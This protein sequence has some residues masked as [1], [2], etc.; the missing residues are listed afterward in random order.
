MGIRRVLILGDSGFMGS[1]L[2][3]FFN[4]KSPDVEV[5]GRSKDSIDLTKED[6]AN[7]LAGLLDTDTAIVMCAA[8]KK[9]LGDSLE[10]FSQNLDMAINVSRLVEQHPVRRVVLFSSAEVYGEDIDGTSVTE[11]APVR[12]TSYYGAAKHVTECLL[13]KAVEN[14]RNSS[15]LVLRPP[16]VYG[17]GDMSRGYGPSGFIWAAL[18]GQEITF[19]GDGEELREFV[20]LD[21]LARIVHELTFSEYDGV[22]NVATGRS[23][24]FKEVL[25]IVARL[26]P[27]ELQVNSRP[28]TRAKIDVGFSNGLLSELSPNLEFTGLEEGIRRTLEAESRHV[29]EMVH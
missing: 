18:N 29:K 25:D 5:V 12:P 23:H 9:Q 11:Q 22:I 19:W 3:Q 2:R 8:I 21:D 15:L 10:I 14:R 6:Q 27:G 26:A 13:R 17:P 4:E 1:R 16:L 28:R 24:T 7:R 20:Y